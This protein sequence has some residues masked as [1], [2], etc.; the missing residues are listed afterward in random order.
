[1]RTFKVC[2][3][4]DVDDEIIQADKLYCD[5]ETGWLSLRRN[6]IDSNVA[7][8]APGKW[9]SYIEVVDEPR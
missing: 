4:P 9:V 1:M 5:K 6:D 8:F 3:H 2:I 7:M